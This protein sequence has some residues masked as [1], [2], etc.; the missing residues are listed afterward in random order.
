MEKIF[1]VKV[2]ETQ[3]A[4]VL[5]LLKPYV[6]LSMSISNQYRESAIKA[7]MPVQAQKAEDKPEERE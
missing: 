7:A 3:I 2:T 5:D 4:L 6:A 1:E